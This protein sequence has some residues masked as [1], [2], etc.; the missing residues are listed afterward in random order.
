MKHSSFLLSRNRS[1]AKTMKRYNK[2]HVCAKSVS[3][4]TIKIKIR[5]MIFFNSEKNYPQEYRKEGQRKKIQK[6]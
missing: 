1:L 5:H 4:I 6:K 3:P 2:T